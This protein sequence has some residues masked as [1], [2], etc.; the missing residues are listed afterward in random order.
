MGRY[1]ATS[2]FALR[3]VLRAASDVACGEWPCC[4]EKK[5]V[6]TVKTVKNF[7]RFELGVAAK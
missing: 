3:R 4:D 5:T 7:E 6:E 1:G 2:R